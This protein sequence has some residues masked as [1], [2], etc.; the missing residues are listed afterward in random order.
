MR[1]LLQH[2]GL[3]THKTVTLGTASDGTSSSGQAVQAE[4]CAA[5]GQTVG[6]VGGID[7]ASQEGVATATAT[8]T[9]AA[10]DPAATS[11]AT[12]AGP[13]PLEAEGAEAELPSHGEACPTS[14]AG[15]P[16]MSARAGGVPGDST[17]TAASQPDAPGCEAAGAAPRQLDLPAGDC[18]ATAA[19]NLSPASG[20]P[21]PTTAEQCQTPAASEA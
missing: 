16:L 7:T 11:G 6:S 17:D 14:G 1:A 4:A 20:R 9:A 21:S 19:S 18:P 2:Q 12:A 10:V 5:A 8:A 13:A 3:P 15:H